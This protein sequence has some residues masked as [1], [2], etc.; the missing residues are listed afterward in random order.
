[1]G[2]NFA[3]A[4]RDYCLDSEEKEIRSNKSTY[5]KVGKAAIVSLAITVVVTSI[6]RM[7]AIT[8]VAGMALEVLSLGICLVVSHDIFRLFDNTQKIYDS[9]VT[10]FRARSTRNSLV[11]HLSNGMLIGRPFVELIKK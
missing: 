1:M 3:N 8:T 4:I 2:F 10:E 6:F 5:C 7:L 11:N 9:A